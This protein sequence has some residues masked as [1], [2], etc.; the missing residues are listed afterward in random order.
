[1]KVFALTELNVNKRNYNECAKNLGLVSSLHCSP[2][3]IYTSRS[4]NS[5]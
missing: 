3:L 4:A 2:F 5:V 1:M